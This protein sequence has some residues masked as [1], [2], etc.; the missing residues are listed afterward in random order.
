MDDLLKSSHAFENEMVN[1]NTLPY[2]NFGAFLV[3]E[4]RGGRV[5]LGSIHEIM[6]TV[7]PDT[8]GS[9]TAFQA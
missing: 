8:S 6:F 7:K 4:S 2:F 3:Q 5:D 9:A 1:K